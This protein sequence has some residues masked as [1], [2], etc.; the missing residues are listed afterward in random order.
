M[1]NCTILLQMYCHLLFLLAKDLGYIG[2]TGKLVLYHERLSKRA[3]RGV[4][5]TMRNLPKKIRH[6][7]K[8][9]HFTKL[10]AP[11]ETARV[12][13]FAKQSALDNP[14]NV[15]YGVSQFGNGFH[16]IGFVGSE[17]LAFETRPNRRAALSS[18]AWEGG[19]GV[20]SS[21]SAARRSSKPTFASNG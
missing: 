16:G 15:V 8:S 21:D 9:T 17:P 11:L 4:C 12:Q 5:K 20:P 19:R 2:H 13:I 1:R 10:L 3:L 18:L 7:S 14:V 6:Y